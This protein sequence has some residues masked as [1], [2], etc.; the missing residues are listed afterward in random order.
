MTK[1]HKQPV[2]KKF[3]SGIVK[4]LFGSSRESTYAGLAAIIVIVAMVTT[5]VFYLRYSEE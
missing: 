3:V 4:T 2:I 5:T 1:Q